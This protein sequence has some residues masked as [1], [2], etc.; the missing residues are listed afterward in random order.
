MNI[1][2]FLGRDT[3]YTS[4]CFKYDIFTIYCREI[5]LIL[6]AVYKTLG[7]LGVAKKEFSGIQPHKAHRLKK[8]L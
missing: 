7:L 6:F 4:V 1:S 2:I 3:D 8:V 5:F